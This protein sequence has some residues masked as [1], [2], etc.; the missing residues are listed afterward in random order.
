M[1]LGPRGRGSEAPEPWAESLLRPPGPRAAPARQR[2]AAGASIATAWELRRPGRQAGEESRRG[3]GERG[4][5]EEGGGVR[6]R[7]RGGRREESTR[8]GGRREKGRKGG[9]EEED[10]RRVGERGG[11]EEGIWRSGDG[12]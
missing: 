4:K 1:F 9:A 8:G 11:G 10:A 12:G 7:K 2:A 6:G 3:A 5:G